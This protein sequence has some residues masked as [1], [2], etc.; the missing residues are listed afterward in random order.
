MSGAQRAGHREH[1]PSGSGA[2]ALASAPCAH[3]TLGVILGI[4]L[5]DRAS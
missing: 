2:L 3:Q 4:Y 5:F 1:S